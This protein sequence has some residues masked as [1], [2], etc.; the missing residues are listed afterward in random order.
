VSS[1]PHPH[2]PGNVSSGPLPRPRGRVRE[3]ADLTTRVPAADL[4]SRG[5]RRPLSLTL[6]PQTGRGDRNPPQSGRGDR[7]PPQ[8]GR[9]DRNSRSPLSSLRLLLFALAALLL[10][11]AAF[12]NPYNVSEVPKLIKEREARKLHGAGIHSTDELLHRA[13]GPAE[14]KQLAKETGLS[15]ARLDQLAR[16]ADLLRLS[17]IGPEFVILLEAAGIKSVP[18]LAA[19]D[20]PALTRKMATLNK[21]RHIAKPA[22]GEALVRNWVG[23]AGKL[24]PVLVKR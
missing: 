10:A 21:S 20:P 7:N 15:G 18:D 12:A 17:D 16:W 14:R 22:P 4:A 6:S 9:G 5:V 19:M 3:R 24:P 11:P 23:Q 13:V 2:L 1:G 8:S